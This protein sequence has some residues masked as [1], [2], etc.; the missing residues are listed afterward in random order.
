MD[1][2]FGGFPHAKRKDKPNAD[3]FHYFMQ[4]DSL[5]EEQVSE[6][7]EAFSL[8]VNILRSDFVRQG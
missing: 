8:F 4:A 1:P 7:K 3:Y 2:A 6:F 5:T